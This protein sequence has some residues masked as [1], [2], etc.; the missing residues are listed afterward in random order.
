[1]ATWDVEY[2]DHFEEWWD[3]LS[4]EEQESVTFVVEMLVD[5]GP[6][7]EHP[8]SSSINGSKHD[9]MRELRIQHKGGPYRVLYAFD[10]RRNAVLLLGGCK[11]GD[12][13]WYIKNIPTADRLYDEHLNALKREEKARKSNA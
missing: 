12:S 5:R 8:Y 9:H 1:M 4:A 11:T 13:R 2:T 6:Q 3:E 7:L 10:P